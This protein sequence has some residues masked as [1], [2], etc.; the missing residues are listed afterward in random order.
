MVA[1]NIITDVDN[2]PDV[3]Q[4]DYTPA[5]GVK[6]VIT[7]FGCSGGAGMVFRIVKGADEAHITNGSSLNTAKPKMTIFL[8]STLSFR[9]RN[10]SGGAQ[11][12]MFSGVEI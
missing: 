4:V 8:D 10:D 9:R 5:A 6:A 11:P 1:G 12:A 3:N 2:I 7:D